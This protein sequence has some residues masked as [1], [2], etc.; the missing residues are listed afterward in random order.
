MV[1]AR[2]RGRWLINGKIT[3]IL[4]PFRALWFRRHRLCASPSSGKSSENL[5]CWWIAIR[6]HGLGGRTDSPRRFN[7]TCPRGPHAGAL[8][9]NCSASI[10]SSPSLA[11][12]VC[13]TGTPTHSLSEPLSMGTMRPAFGRLAENTQH[14]A[15]FAPM[16]RIRRAS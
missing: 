9:P 16:R 13:V 2:Q 11:P 3:Q 14:V 10:Q 15:V 6:R 5:P 12:W 7:D 1:A 8:A 4:R